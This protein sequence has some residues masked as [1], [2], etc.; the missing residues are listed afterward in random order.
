[1]KQCRLNKKREDLCVGDLVT[2]SAL[3]DWAEEGIVT[4]LIIKKEIYHGLE[5]LTIQWLNQPSWS[6]T[7]MEENFEWRGSPWVT[8]IIQNESRY[9]ELKVIQ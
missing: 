2:F 8:S 6:L 4:A 5:L 3:Q 1:M 9:H 7:F